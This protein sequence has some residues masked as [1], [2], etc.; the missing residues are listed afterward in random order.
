MNR[1]KTAFLILNGEMDLKQE[2]YRK[3]LN[4]YKE[5]IYC[6]DGG[7]K[8]ARALEFVPRE[9]WGD[10]DSV[11]KEDLEWAEKKGAV[12][13]KFNRDKDK[14][15]GELLIEYLKEKGYDRILILA[16]LGG[17]TD[18]MLGNLNLAF[19][20]KGLEFISEKERVMALENENI[21][22]G[23]KGKTVSLIPFSD[24]VK[25]ITLKGFLY[26]LTDHDLERGD[27]LCTSNV[28]EEDKV[29]IKFESGKM[30]MIIEV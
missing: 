16:G 28:A 2:F 17:R 8:Y 20:Y 24:S 4:E 12:L 22:E 23:L 9:V 6:A 18:H 1:I 19:K 29:F 27:S 25:K 15:D 3:I 26:P 7:L 13:K 14:T 5:N 11:E 21:I 10:F 30:L